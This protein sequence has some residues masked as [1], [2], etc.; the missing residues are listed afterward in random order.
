MSMNHGEY[1]QPCKRDGVGR[2]GTQPNADLKA[3][4]TGIGAELRTLH[5]DVLR[6]EVLDWD[7]GVAKEAQS[8]KGRIWRPLVRAA[9]DPW[10]RDTL[11][12]DAALL[13]PTPIRGGQ[14]PRARCCASRRESRQS[15]QTRGA[16]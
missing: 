14:T 15:L 7:G 1:R 5:S 3:V 2:H 12:P 6:E 16:D 13:A 8:A 4:R 9:G 11:G 10:S